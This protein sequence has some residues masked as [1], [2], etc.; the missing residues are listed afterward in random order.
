MPFL[1]EGTVTDEQAKDDA[2]ST[3]AVTT[4]KVLCAEAQAIHGKK[5]EAVAGK[6]G[7]A[8]Y[9]A[10]NGL[11]SAALCLSGGGI[12][13]AAFGLGV[14]QALAT[15]PR[16]VKD[17]PVAKPEDSLLAKFHFL[18][19]VSGGG[20]IGS[21]LSAWVT[22][23]GFAE[24]WSNLVGRPKGPD[25]EPP[26][27][28]W[29][30]SY[31]N[32]LA[33]K[34]GLTSAD[35]WGAFAIVL[36]NL[37][38]NWLVI[39]PVLCLALLALKGFA[40]AVAWFSQF[41]PRTCDPWFFAAAAAGCI[42]LFLALHFTTRN[43]PTRGSS[44]AGQTAFLWYDLV[45]ALLSGIFFTFALASPCAFNYLYELPMPAFSWGGASI[46]GLGLAGGLVIYFLG[47]ITTLPK[48]RGWKDY[49]A[50]LFAWLCAGAVY[51]ALMAL[52]VYLYV[53]V[54]GPG[55]GWFAPGEVLLIV[56]GVP[57]ALTS[58]LLAE[59]IFVALSS[60]EK[61]SDSDREWLGRAA[62]WYLL[63]ILAWPVLMFLVFVA[64]P[65]VG[66]VYKDIRAWATGLGTGGVIAWLGKSGLTPAK[67]AAKDAKGL[68]ANVILAIAAP[69]FAVVLIIMISSVLDHVLFGDALIR[70]VAFKAGVTLDTFPPWP[71]GW[72]LLGGAA[73]AFAIGAVASIWVNINRFSLH[74]MY[75]NR[76][77]RSF[78]GASQGENRHANKFTDFDADDNRPMHELRLQHDTRDPPD[79]PKPIWRPFHVINIALNIVSTKRLAWQERKAESFTVSALHAGTACGG[80]VRG[81]DGIV[82]AYGAYRPSAK[83]GGGISLGTA[84]AISGAAASPNMGYNS[85]P[86]VA[87]L[88][89]L[90]NV[91]LGWW[92][93]NPA[94][95]KENIYGGEGPRLAIG[96]LLNEMFG[97]TTDDSNHVYLSDGGHFENLGLYEM[98]RRRCK[99]I[100]V[101]DAGCD[102]NFTFEDLGNAVRKIQL[103]LGVKITMSKLETLRKRGANFEVGPDKPYWAVGEIDYSVD[104]DNKKGFL[105]YIKPCYHGVESTGVRAYAIANPLFPHQ[106][107]GDQFFSESQFE[108]YRSLGFEITD[109]VLHAAFTGPARPTHWSLDE[110]ANAL[111]TTVTQMAEAIRPSEVHQARVEMISPAQ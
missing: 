100:V 62:G 36:R 110:I 52:G 19:T 91:R 33:P 82:R 98:V 29:L 56:F 22:R 66:D 103:D 93:G 73:L 48:W 83:Y 40:I 17:R 5:A 21:W 108:S 27:I 42:S 78:L 60:Y 63:V 101:S 64:G 92:L 11:D 90:F 94:I 39:L 47:W 68:S 41:D 9:R 96:A 44:N 69:V 24:V 77:I 99:F 34:L 84:L 3:K 65:L 26:V 8:L 50:D 102:P 53:K 104:G 32:Y 43:R 71:G 20:Y 30:R 67:G 31:S 88:M 61:D 70:T 16:P 80:L 25:V 49:F 107:T 81:N 55:I 4:E 57:W 51:G 10:L 14:I 72:W 95:E 15:H 38:L 1:G 23:A 85:S 28:A 35:F 75:R 45:P 58:Q 86:A 89:T 106:P 105:L 37:L 18:S 74:A 46:F 97:Q 54:Y 111:R 87:F 79:A 6:S 13:S 76:L 59:M 2:D 12:R 109:E 7:T